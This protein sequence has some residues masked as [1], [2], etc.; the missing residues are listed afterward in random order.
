MKYNYKQ[1]NERRALNLIEQIENRTNKMFQESHPELEKT[2]QEVATLNA[3]W[4]YLINQLSKVLDQ[5]N[6]EK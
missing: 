3:G 4:P 2:Y 6:K 5:L 1:I